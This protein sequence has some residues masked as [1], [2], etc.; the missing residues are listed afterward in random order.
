VTC[1]TLN[2]QGSEVRGAPKVVDVERLNPDLRRAKLEGSAKWGH[3][4]YTQVEGRGPKRDP[5]EPTTLGTK[6]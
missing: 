4:M 6:L 1:Q 5:R 2:L 3:E